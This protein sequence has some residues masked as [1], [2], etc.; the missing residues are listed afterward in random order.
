MSGGISNLIAA[1]LSQAAYPGYAPPA[2]WEPLAGY[3]TSIT[4]LAGTNGFTSF[5]NKTTHQIVIAFK[6]TDFSS[7]TGG[8]LQLVSDL[9]NDG[10]S[11]WESIAAQFATVLT[12]IQQNPL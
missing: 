11:A 8:L 9:K 1:E 2:G 10:G 12:Q 7:T 6:G 4:S 5:L 3:S